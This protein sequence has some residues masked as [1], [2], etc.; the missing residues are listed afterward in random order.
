M[1]HEKR[2]TGCRLRLVL[3]FIISAFTLFAQGKPITLN[4]PDGRLKDVIENL[5][6]QTNYQFFYEDDL[7]LDRTIVKGIN[8]KDM[9]I[10]QILTRVLANTNITHKVDGK[11]IY[12]MRR[13]EQKNIADTQQKE[14]RRVTG[15]VFDKNGE[16]LIG[17]NVL[18]VGTTNGTVTDINGVFNLSLTKS[19]SHL[20][21][22]YI[23]FKEK[24]VPVGKESHIDIILEEDIS[25][26]DEVV[27]IG[28]GQQKKVS[29][30]GAISS[31]KPDLLQTNQTRSLTNGLAGQI[32]GIIAVQRSGEPGFDNSD[33]WIRGINTFGANSNPLVLIDGVERSMNNISPEEIESFSVL[34]DATATAVYGVRGANGVIIIQTKKGKIGKPTITFK[35]DFGVSSPTQL[36]EFTDAAKYMEV[37]NEASVLSGLAPIYS[38]KYINK[39]RIGYDPDLYPDVNWMEAVMNKYS[40]TAKGSLDING[41]SERLKYSL[42]LSYFNEKG[43][44]VTDPTNNYDSQLKM[45]KYNVRSNVDLSL[46]S[47][48]DINVSLGGYINDRNAP[49]VGVSTIFSNIMDTPPNVHPILYSNG[50]IP[51]LPARYNPWARATQTGYQKRFESNIESSVV[52]TQNIGKLWSSLEGLTVRGLFS[53]DAFNYHTQNRTKTPPSFQAVGRNEE[54]ELITTVVDQGQEFLGYSRGAGGNRTI[55]A[56]GRLNYNRNFGVHRA[57]G[58][59]LFNFKD[60]V[61]QDA[62]SAILSLPYRNC[63]IAGRAAYSYKDTYFTEFNFG[64]NGSENFKRGYRFGFF[65][66]VAVGWMLTNEEWMAPLTNTLSKFKIRGSWGIVGN[67]QIVQNRR[68]AYISTISSVPG[69]NFGYTNNIS[70]GGYREG[71]FGIEDMTWETSEKMDIGIELGFWESIDLQ[72]DLFKEHRSNI[73]MQR[74]TIPEISGYNQMPYANFGKVD[75][76]GI[77]AELI[78]N[79]RFNKDFIVSMRGNFT[80]AKNKIIE[81]D[82]PESIKET[83]RA[84]TGQSINQHFGLIAEGLFTEDDFIDASKGILRDDIPNHTFGRVQ[85]GDIKYKDLNRDNIIDSYDEIPIGKPYVPEIIY[86]F[87]LNFQYKNFDFGAFFQ[88]AG[89]FTNMLYGSTLIPGSGG[90]GVGNIYANV[91]D[92]W[93]PENPRQNVFWPRLANIESQNN[94]RYSTWWLRDAS[95]LR[96]KNMELGYTLPKAWQSTINSK[97]IRLFLRGSNLLTFAKFKMWDPEIGSQNGLRYPLNKICTVGF[98]ITF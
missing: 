14:G 50:Q 79:H 1:K 3:L 85:P 93:T 19:D 30:I 52:L 65:P 23:G 4:I 43:M 40:P 20:K 86:G 61:I 71:D 47:S 34:K 60:R 95:Y 7:D 69:Y 36:P 75:N 63:G 90:G 73:F 46:T 78:V 11:V 35:T 74:K 26:L 13:N 96:L 68:F 81:Y 87:G 72:I 12:L 44:I 24:E 58:L 77:E 97:N 89:N 17:V 29:V 80:Y 9:D 18:E 16:L 39:T 2:R 22:T 21:F 59:F 41:G 48:T 91:D 92:R 25:E 5:S 66:A 45:T 28:Y 31:I 82:E 53:F 38:E 84:R 55:Y 54:G 70:Y 51:K 67:D 62:S 57:D 42:I 64:Y 8:V 49:G 94:M 33:F 76:K 88:G 32:P 98:E 10:N 83:T 6:E 56:E 37:L 15:R 27:V